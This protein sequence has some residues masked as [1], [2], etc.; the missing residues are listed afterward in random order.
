RPRI[1]TKPAVPPVPHTQRRSV[2]SHTSPGNS[3]RRPRPAAATPGRRKLPRWQPQCGPQPLTGSVFMVLILF[4]SVKNK[5]RT[6]MGKEKR[7]RP[8]APPS[9]S[10]CQPVSARAS[11]RGQRRG[12][13]LHRWLGGHRGFGRLGLLLVPFDRLGLARE[14]ARQHLVHARDGND[15]EALL[16]AL[17]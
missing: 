5:E 17:A 3:A 15:V 13:G 14:R 2:S 7:R 11:M 6:E 16:D 4:L 10:N 9:H 1:E 12:I 8:E